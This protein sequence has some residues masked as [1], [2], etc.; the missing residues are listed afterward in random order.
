MRR[1]R[2]VFGQAVDDRYCFSRNDGLDKEVWTGGCSFGIQPLGIPVG[3]SNQTRQACQRHISVQKSMCKRKGFRTKYVKWDVCFQSELRRQESGRIKGT[4]SSCVGEGRFS[5]RGVWRAESLLI[6]RKDDK[7]WSTEE[8]FTTLLSAERLTSSSRG[9]ES[10]GETRIG[11]PETF[12]I[13]RRRF[14]TSRTMPQD[15]LALSLT[16]NPEMHISKSPDA[17]IVHAMLCTC[18]S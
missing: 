15:L 9:A 13:L 11:G 7:A 3:F 14:L 6:S 1:S 10:P 17:T 18:H 5:P 12:S 4:R 8:G 2:Y 16:M